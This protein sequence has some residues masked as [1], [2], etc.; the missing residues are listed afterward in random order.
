VGEQ[1]HQHSTVVV[2]ALDV[3]RDIV[4]FPTFHSEVSC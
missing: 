1:N 4:Y 3:F 2:V